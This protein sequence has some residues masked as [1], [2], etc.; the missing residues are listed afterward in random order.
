MLDH[1][2]RCV[3]KTFPPPV[4]AAN[5]VGSYHACTAGLV[6]LYHMINLESLGYHEEDLRC[7]TDSVG[8]ALDILDFCKCLDPVAR[9]MAGGLKEILTA[10][11]EAQ[12]C[13]MATNNLYRYMNHQSQQTCPRHLETFELLLASPQQTFRMGRALQMLLDWLCSPF[14]SNNNSMDHSQSGTW[15]DQVPFATHMSTSTMFEALPTRLPEQEGL[16]IFPR[17]RRAHQED[18]HGYCQQLCEAH[19]W[20][21]ERSSESY[22]IGAQNLTSM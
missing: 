2:V 10:F 11:R 14:G 12:S 16:N 3:I 7:S 18:R 9:Q 15:Y 6:L 1:D 17:Q 22:I 13:D 21:T 8:R 19:Y 20:L 4:I 5:C